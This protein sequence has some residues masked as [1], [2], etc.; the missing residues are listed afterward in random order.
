MLFGSISGGVLTSITDS[1][2]MKVA[3]LEGSNFG[4]IRV[5]GTIGWGSMSLVVGELNKLDTSIL[6]SYVPGFLFFVCLELF[7]TILMLCNLKKMRMEHQKSDLN[8]ERRPTLEEAIEQSISTRTS[9]MLSI[10]QSIEHTIENSKI[11]EIYQADENREKKSKQI[12]KFFFLTCYQ[13]PMLFKHIIICAVI[14]ML[15]ALNWNFFPLFLEKDLSTNDTNLIEQDS[16]LSN[17]NSRLVGL[18]ALVQCFAGEV[19]FMYFASL[20]VDKIGTKASLNLVLLTF[21]FRYFMYTFFT[22]SIAYY[23]LFVEILHGVTFG[24]FYYV[25]NILARDYSKKMFKV[26]FDYLIKNVYNQ[27]DVTIEEGCTTFE[28]QIQKTIQLPEDDDSTFATMQSVMSASFEGFGVAIGSLIAGF[29]IQN[30]GF[31]FVWYLSSGTAF[32]MFLFDL[33]LMLI[34]YLRNKFKNNKK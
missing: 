31:K 7:D 1:L 13:H 32:V 23:I 20:I 14:G 5:W 19:P 15:T 33:I 12:S 21:S 16:T 2:V 4:K 9:Q 17:Q 26:E 8:R 28:E 29:V 11:Q 24:L 22:P 6:P 25:M 27:S 34:I 30:I 10:S 18:T 3:E